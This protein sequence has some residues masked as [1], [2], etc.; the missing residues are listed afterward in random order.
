MKSRLFY[1]LTYLFFG[2][3]LSTNQLSGQTH[4]AAPPENLNKTILEL[5]GNF[6]KSYNSCDVESFKTFLTEDLEFYHDKGGLTSSLTTFM[7]QVKKGLCGDNTIRLRREAVEGSVSVYPLNN[8]GAIISGEHVFYLN[9]KGK[10]EK[11]VEAAKFTHVWQLK[12]GTWKMSRVL[13]YDHKPISINSAKKEITVPIKTLTDFAGQYK[14]PNT[15]NVTISVKDNV[16]EMK[17]GEMQSK[18][19]PESQT[20]F[21][22]KQAPLTFEFVRDAQGKV[23]KFIVRENGEIAEEAK[24]VD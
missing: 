21:F 6:W 20:V 9:E 7:E 1:Q 4:N 14:A 11:L 8:Y 15:G 18:I 16:L 22:H 17:A 24:R 19:Y 3:V 12:N 2:V 13:S 5:D 23:I 10:K